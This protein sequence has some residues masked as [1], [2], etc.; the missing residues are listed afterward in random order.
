M[1]NPQPQRVQLADARGLITREWLRW[2][3]T[4][5]TQ[6][7]TVS[8]EDATLAAEI[9]A[10]K[11]ADIALDARIDALESA[12]GTLTGE[13][14][15]NPTNA[16]EVD[17]TFF[18]PEMTATRRVWLSFANGTDADE[19][20]PEMLDV[21]SMAAFSGAGTLRVLLSFGTLTTG[22]IRLQYLAV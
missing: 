2:F 18:I 4:L 9:A 11:A 21:L 14:L 8:A 7:D 5:A 10:L 6:I 19:N 3:E 20:T 16:M 15:V 1:I 22:P 13:I 17:Q 12:A